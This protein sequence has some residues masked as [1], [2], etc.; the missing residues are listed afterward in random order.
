M[1]REKLG[2]DDLM[3]EAH[4]VTAALDNLTQRDGP[5]ITAVPLSRGKRVYAQLLHY[6]RTAKMSKIQAHTLQSAL[7]LIQARLRFFDEPV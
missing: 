4:S 2:F 5:K 6:Q 3:I 7:E 1:T